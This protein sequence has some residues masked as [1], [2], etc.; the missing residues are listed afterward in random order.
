MFVKKA[1]KMYNKKQKMADFNFPSN[2]LEQT[3]F[4]FRI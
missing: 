3:F 4:H 2:L 1:T